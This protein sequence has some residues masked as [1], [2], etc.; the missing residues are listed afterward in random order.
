MR[1]GAS[2][3]LAMSPMRGRT[4]AVEQPECGKHESTGAHRGNSACPRRQFA[5]H[6]QSRCDDVGRLLFGDVVFAGSEG[7][8]RRHSARHDQ[9]VDA[10]GYLGKRH[11]DLERD[12]RRRLDGLTRRRRQDHAVP[13]PEVVGAG[14]DLQRR[15]DVLQ[16]HLVVQG[17][18]HR[19]E[20]L[21]SSAVR[22]P[23]RPLLVGHLLSF[24]DPPWRFASTP[25]G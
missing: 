3:L 13:R 24:R 22:G 7:E 4:T 16:R 15:G 5:H 6:L 23:A 8:V 25:A 21:R 14:E 1:I 2:Q 17:E 12:E 18:H 11:V 10:V 19:L 9:R 20:W